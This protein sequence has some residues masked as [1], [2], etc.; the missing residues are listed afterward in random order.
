M[1]RSMFDPLLKYAC[2]RFYLIC[3]SPLRYKSGANPICFASART[4]SVRERRFSET[5]ALQTAILSRGA[6]AF[7]TVVLG[8]QSGS[9]RPPA[10]RTIVGWRTQVC[11]RASFSFLCRPS[12]SISLHDPTHHVCVCARV[13]ARARER[14]IKRERERDF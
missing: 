14:E 9:Y 3:E 11:I 5:S 4:Q 12:F 7:L 2:E 13:C 6:P 1:A 10:E 8:V